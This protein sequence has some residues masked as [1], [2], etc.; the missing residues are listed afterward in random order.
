MA[1]VGLVAAV[2][3]EIGLPPIGGYYVLNLIYP[4]WL[5]PI[6]GAIRLANPKSY[7]ACW[8]YRHNLP[9]YLRAVQRFGLEQEH[10]EVVAHRAQP[11]AKEEQQRTP[12]V[13]QTSNHSK[14]QEIISQGPE[15]IG[16]TID[17]CCEDPKQRAFAQALLDAA[18]QDYFL[19]QLAMFAHT[20][21]NAHD[22]INRWKNAGLELPAEGTPEFYP[23]DN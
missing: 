1:V 5:L 3:Q 19:L 4:L 2:A 21:V 17:A 11:A 9:K 10:A 22:M 6:Y 20:K 12:E 15:R 14:I 13:G 7:Y 16:P 18:L 8:F 23:Y